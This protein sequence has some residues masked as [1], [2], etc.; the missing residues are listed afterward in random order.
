MIQ[1]FTYLHLHDDKQASFTVCDGNTK[2]ELIFSFTA[3]ARL[4]Y[5]K[6]FVV[7]R[8]LKIFAEKVRKFSHEDESF[9]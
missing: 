2:D 9:L 4:P 5:F 8:Q 7:G 1:V 3:E 6:F